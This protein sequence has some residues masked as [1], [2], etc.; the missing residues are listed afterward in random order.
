MTHSIRL[1][2]SD[3]VAILDVNASITDST[4]VI[5][6]HGPESITLVSDL[7]DRATAPLLDIGGTPILETT[8]EG[9]LVSS[10]RIEDVQ[11]SPDSLKLTAFGYWNALKDIPYSMLWSTTDLSRWRVVQK[12]EVSSNDPDKFSFSIQNELRISLQKNTSYGNSPWTVGG[13][14]LVR[15][16]G[17][18]AQLRCIAFDVEILLPSGWTFRFGSFT[19]GFGTFTSHVTVAATGSTQKLSYVWGFANDIVSLD[20]YRASANATYTGET[21]DAYVKITNVRVAGSSGDVLNTTIT[22]ARTNG[23]SVAVAVGSTSG[24]YVGQRLTLAGGG[25]REG[26]AVEAIVSNTQIT[27]TITNAPSGG[28]PV[29]TTVQG[30]RIFADRIVKDIR[31]VISAVNPLQLQ[32]SD[33]L[34]E[35]PGLDLTEMIFEDASMAD[36]LDQ[37]AQLG[38]GSGEV[39][40]AGVTPE[41]FLFFRPQTRGQ[42]TWYV[43]VTD[44]YTL[45][46]STAN[47]INSRYAKYQDANGDT[48]R[49]VSS[50][51]SLSVDFYNLLRRAAVDVDT[52]ISQVAAQVV[53][54]ALADDAANIPRASITTDALYNPLGGRARRWEIQPGDLCV[55][56][57]LAATLSS[58]IEQTRQFRIGRV[59]FKNDS[60]TIEPENPTP[61][62]ETLLA[63]LSARN[64]S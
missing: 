55:L 50:A 48:V 23:T 63:R 51:N 7:G 42:R 25:N 56:R 12:S 33:S 13:F 57:N 20:I 41:R 37:L 15:P 3:T 34:I 45:E 27:A 62:L 5:G 47:L 59:T 38:S 54:T 44:S 52:T 36:V 29:G 26:I 18:S 4:I 1:K 2:P 43:D 53:A 10:G 16:S 6:P 28:F 17:G 19:S 58:D 40:R 8:D 30:L 11:A 24:M 32:A 31:A 46:R 49:G 9:V 61:K 35:A 21:G 22:T 14:C 64:T 39:W 60:I